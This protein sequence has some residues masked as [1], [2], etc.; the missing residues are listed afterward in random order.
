MKKIFFS[1][2]AIAAIASCA[3]TEDVYTE[4][5]TEIQLAPVTALTTKAQVGVIDGTK[6]PTAENFNVYAYWANQPAGS[7]FNTGATVY[8]DNVKFV[9]KGKYW[10]GETTYYWPKNGSLRFA[11][12][13]PADLSM[14]HDLEKDLYRLDN[15]EYVSDFSGAYD[16]LVAPTSE[17]YTAQT[18]AEKVSVVFE[19]AL[20][21]LT[22]KVQSTAVA[23]GTFTVH[24]ITVN[25]VAI[26]GSLLADMFAGEKNWTVDPTTATAIQAYAGNTTVTTTVQNLDD[27]SNL[28]LPQATTTLTIEFTQNEMKDKDNN[29]TTPKLENQT[30]TIPLTLDGDEPWVAG[31]HY[32][33]TVIFDLDEILINPSVEDWVEVEVP[34]IDATPVL[35][36][37]YEELQAAVNT[38]RSV[39]LTQDINLTTKS[40]EVG[41]SVQ[42]K[43]D[44]AAPVNVV[45]DLNG[46]SITAT[47]TD[48]IVVKEGATLTIN[49]NGKVW[50]ATDDKSAGNAVWVKHGNVTINGGSYYVGADN[51]LRNDCIYV[52][53][54]SQKDNAANYQSTV[55]INGGRFEAKVKE[56]NQY[57]VL[58]IQDKHAENGSTIT[59]NGGEFVNFD[60]SNN[61]SEG[62]NTNFLGAGVGSYE[63]EPGLWTVVKK[64]SEIRIKSAAALQDAAFHGAVA[65]LDANL[66]LTESILVTGALT[67]NLNDKN[68]IAEK[69]DAIVIDNNGSLVIN[70]RGAVKAATDDAS[71]ANA[72]W[73]KYG[74]AVLNGGDYYVGKDGAE[75]NDCIYVGANAYVADA[76][77]KVST[78]TINGGKYEAAAKEY[79]QY[80]VLNL[81]DEFYKAGSQIIVK[82]G[83]FV[84]FDPANNISEGAN[85]NFVPKGW[86]SIDNGNDTWTVKT[87]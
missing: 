37:N 17:S 51:T 41:K 6:Y 42:T 38:G 3:K 35:V 81:R 30:V 26:K 50:A 66:D 36:E 16:I 40:L 87:E 59:V 73:L 70:G 53:A 33:Y 2:L 4:G 32:N 58:N 8:L 80:W 72:I 74:T 54:D 71:S 45:I 84:N 1:L 49:G 76:A 34:A 28:V 82:G 29:V 15:H 85:T 13:S 83:T 27:Y 24:K 52:G 44:E 48:A 19:H 46:K 31:K 78:L 61:L 47:S 14:I 79:D 63:L 60:P 7:D 67:L 9:N 65:V 43:A 55:V 25:D 75:R 21:W 23:E 69:T 77:T 22:F 18:A 20:S 56:L 12:Y 10:G 11:A 64:D 57:W 39:R 68:L 5:Q 86:K 62:A